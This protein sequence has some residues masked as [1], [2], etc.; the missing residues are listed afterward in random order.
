CAEGPT[1]I[2][3]KPLFPRSVSVL[4]RSGANQSDRMR[5]IIK[6]L[7]ADLL[8]AFAFGREL[9]V[10]LNGFLGHDLVRLLRTTHQCEVFPGCDSFMTVT[11]KAQAEHQGF[12]AI[13]RRL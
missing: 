7:T 13:G 12:L 6:L 1:S 10:D 3:G 11:I 5:N 2:S 4:V 9:F 8:K